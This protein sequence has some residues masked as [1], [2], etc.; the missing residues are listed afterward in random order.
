MQPMPTIVT[1]A[2]FDN[3]LRL[4][5][6]SAMALAALARHCGQKGRHPNQMKP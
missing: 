2:G 1:I 6:S 4:Q 3:F 5:D